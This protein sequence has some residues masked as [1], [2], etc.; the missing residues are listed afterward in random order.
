MTV[1]A[2]RA[3]VFITYDSVINWVGKSNKLYVSYKAGVG[4][5]H[6]LDPVSVYHLTGNGFL[7][8]K[9]T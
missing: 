9:I 5:C 4:A 6:A 2:F 8:K 7:A 3:G 1:A